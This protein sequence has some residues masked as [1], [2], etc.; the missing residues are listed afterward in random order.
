LSWIK[1]HAS[2]AGNER[3]AKAGANQVIGPGH[4]KYYEAAASLSQNLITK[5][6]QQWQ[7]KFCKQSKFFIQSKHYKIQTHTKT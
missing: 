4:Y 6:N 5:S 7:Q 1:A 2:H 3:L